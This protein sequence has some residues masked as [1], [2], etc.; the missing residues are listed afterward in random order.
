[1]FAKGAC[2]GLLPGVLLLSGCFSYRPAHGPAPEPGAH[3]SIRLSRDASRELAMKLGPGVAYVEGV[4]LADDSAG[5]HLA[6]KRVEGGA[7]TDAVWTGEPVTFPH[8]AYL[9]LEE[10]RLNLPGT[11]IFGGLAVGAVVAIRQAFGEGSTLNTQPG[12]VGSP[13]Q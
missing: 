12:S 7:E 8:D 10:R 5:L 4:V 13:S 2:V 6:V 11:V 3:V 1:M 9:S